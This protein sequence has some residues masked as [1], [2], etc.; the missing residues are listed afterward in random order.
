MMTRG[1]ISIDA[2]RCKG[3]Q[4]CST[5]CPQQVIHMASDCLNAKGYHPVALIDPEQLCTGCAICAVICPDICITVYRETVPKQ[6]HNGTQE[7]VR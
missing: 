5:V 7:A 4:L 3:C 1:M 2:E 6:A